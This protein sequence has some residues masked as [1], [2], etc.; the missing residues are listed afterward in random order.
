[1]VTLKKELGYNSAHDL[2]GSRMNECKW[3]DCNEPARAKSPFCSGT[4]KKRYQR[5]SGTNV[6]VEVGQG[7]SGTDSCVPVVTVEG[8]ALLKEI[9]KPNPPDT[10]LAKQPDLT[11]L[12]PGVSPP[13]GQRTL[14]T[15]DMTAQRLKLRVSSYNNLTWVDS[16]EYAETVYRLQT[17]TVDELT[18]SGQTVPQWKVSE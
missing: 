7:P 9:F 5:A 1:V 10:I 12:P 16:P 18:A 13:T 3:K 14:A 2:K 6:P 15:A 8:E 4:C 17:M 11:T